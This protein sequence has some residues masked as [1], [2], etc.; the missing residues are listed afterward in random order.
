MQKTILLCC[1]VLLCW[2]LPGSAQ[3]QIQIGTIKGTATDP[4]DSLVPSAHLTLDNPVTGYHGTALTGQ[5]GEF[6]FHNVPFGSYTL[7]AVGSGF[8]PIVQTISLR[9]NI[10]VVADIKLSLAGASESVTVQANGALV[11]P[12]SSSTETRIDENSIQRL[13]GA[14]R[15]GQLQRV[16][17]TAPGWRTENDGL[18][19]IRG[20]D[21]GV[22]YVMDGIPITDRLDVV[23]GSS[24]DTTMIR[25]VNVIT[26][27]IPAEFGG[28]SGA[29]VTVQSKSMIDNPLTGSFGLG[30]GSFRAGEVNVTLG[31]NF[32]RKLGIFITGTASRSGRFLDP[33]DPRNFNNRGGA[34]RLNVRS[35]WEPTAEDLL[36]FTVSANGTDFHVTNDLD[37]ELAG[38]RQREGLRDNSES[39]RWQRVWSPETVTDLAYFRQSYEASLTGSTFDTPLF[40]NQ[41]R[42]NVRQGIIASLTR[43]YRGQTVKAGFEASRVSLKEFFT[44]AI[45]DRDEALERDISEA[46]LAFDLTNPFLFRDGKT[47]GQ[48]SFYLQDAFS[49]LKNLTVNAGLRYDHSNLLVSDQQFSPRIGAVYYIDGTRTAVRGSFNRLYMPPQVENLLLASSEQARRLSPFATDE[50]GGSALVRPEKVSAYEIGFAQDVFGLFKLDGAYWYRS[51]RNYDDPN[52]FFNTTLIFPNSVAEGFARGVDVRVDV[53]ERKGWSAHLSY[54]NARILQTG[55]LNGGLFLTSELIEIGPGTRFIPDHDVRNTASFALNYS[56]RSR[57]LWASLFG[58]YESGVPLEVEEAKLEE[59]RSLPGADLVDFARSRVKPWSVFDLSLGWD[60]FR[61]KR[62]MVRAQLDIENITNRRFVYNFGN[63]FSGTH[64]GNPRLWGGRLKFTIR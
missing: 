5:Q 44:F 45:T 51:F 31:G 24:P 64:F 55:P 6:V 46:A 14:T 47:R 41:D 7:R 4:T 17:A 8:Q 42:R 25:S 2:S 49:P 37:Q 35:D 63:P 57:G 1:L 50:S 26:G 58:R 3:A 33:V 62:V 59:L 61:E 10:P 43:L 23:N 28:R 54:G 48:I 15:G 21:D 56:W 19:H 53:P 32:K 60:F 16:I 38:Q 12:D 39:I 29:V 36:L 40:A 30:G 22:L 34:L 18:L 11:E 13:P 27:N 9:S 52:V 20:V